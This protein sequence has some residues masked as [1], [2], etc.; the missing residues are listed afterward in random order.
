MVAWGVEV[1]LLSP[2]LASEAVCSTGPSH[3]AL[4]HSP[5]RDS[6][7]LQQLPGHPH[8]K[9]EPSHS[10]QGSKDGLTWLPVLVL[11]YTHVACCVLAT[12]APG[13]S[14]HVLSAFD[15]T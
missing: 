5:G 6:C 13:S 11:S 4:K 1:V 8:I 12:L 15:L 7:S 2:S 14:A 10:V 3:L 9:L